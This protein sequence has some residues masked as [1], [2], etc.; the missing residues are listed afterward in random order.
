[1]RKLLIPLLLFLS[2]SCKS[3]T[4][5]LTNSNHYFLDTEVSDFSVA[6]TLSTLQRLDKEL[7]AGQPLY[8]VLKTPGG[9]V[10]AGMDLIRGVKHLS[11]PITTISIQSISMGFQ[12]VEAL[13]DRL[14]VS[15]GIMMTHPIAGVCAGRPVQVSSCLDFMTQLAD[16]LD[17]QVAKRMNM[18]LASYK[19]ASSEEWFTVGQGAIDSNMADRIVTI[20]CDEEMNSKDRCPY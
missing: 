1:M 8:L 17:V 10:I 4:V 2:L 18:S 20:K 16:T 14:I 15:D 12:I 9:S 3:E 6:M 5:L 7:P 13:G 11:R 19:A